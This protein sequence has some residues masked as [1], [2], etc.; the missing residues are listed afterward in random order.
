MFDEA[1]KILDETYPYWTTRVLNIGQ[2]V[3][4]SDIDTA[5]VGLEKDSD[6]LV[7]MFNPEFAKS[8]TDK[9]KAYIM[10]HEAMHV[11][12]NDISPKHLETYENQEALNIAMDCIINDTLNYNGMIDMMPDG[13]CT[14]KNIVEYDCR[15]EKLG[16][17][18]EDVLK[19]MEGSEGEPEESVEG[20]SWGDHDSW[21]S[22]EMQEKSEEL[23]S[24][25]DTAH[26][27][28][29]EEEDDLELDESGHIGI[30]DLARFNFKKLF[31]YMDPDMYH[32]FGLTYKTRADWRRPRRSTAALHPRV[33]LP[34]RREN[35]NE[36]IL[37]SK[38]PEIV[39]FI[40]NSG[41]VSDTDKSLFNEIIKELPKD[42]ADYIFVAVA[43]GSKELTKDEIDKII[44]GRGDLPWVGHGNGWN[45]RGRK[46]E[47]WCNTLDKL[48]RNRPIVEF[49]VAHQWILN[50]IESGRLR[51]YPKAVLMISDAESCLVRA[52]K[53][54]ASR[55]LVIHNGKNYMAQ[56]GV[57]R[58]LGK[59][60]FGKPCM[61]IPK[62][63]RNM[64]TF[65]EG[66]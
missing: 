47:G 26:K 53:Q 18:Y 37:G 42:Y 6:E 56:M 15:S 9:E 45:G 51:G 17:V 10:S 40:D 36:M 50:N 41:S 4:S 34:S 57:R 11:I 19:K 59:S 3:L 61:L 62:N 16:K 27:E 28:A 33:M 65:T 44:R 20:N 13:G 66:K 7:F 60:Y 49:E 29:I 39:V 24:P 8:L 25:S 5:A 1:L 54:Q 30:R 22:P 14:G 2:P 52:S 46:P 31:S 32:G 48:Y 23:S 58:N 64:K 43:T 21:G 55:W 35:K 12:R 38:R 63:F